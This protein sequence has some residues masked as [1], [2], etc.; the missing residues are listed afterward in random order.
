MVNTW[1]K[2]PINVQ[3]SSKILRM[4]S[5]NGCPL[6]I[7]YRNVKISKKHTGRNWR[8]ADIGS[9]EKYRERMK[10]TVEINFVQNG[11]SE[12]TTVVRINNT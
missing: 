3:K 4:T 2:K 6:G 7:N 11:S 5:K 8:L 12:K 10:D 9:E 1:I